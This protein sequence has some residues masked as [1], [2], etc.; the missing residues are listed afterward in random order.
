MSHEQANPKN[1]VGTLD[2]GLID[3]VCASDNPDRPNSFVII[4][5][6]RVIHCNTDTPEEMHHWI[7]LLQKPKGDAKIDGQEFLVRGEES[8]GIW[9]SLGDSRGVRRTLEE[10][11]GVWGSL[12]DSR[13]VRRSL[14]SLEL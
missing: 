7:S 8:G 14:G 5:A 3:S 12:G 11:G 13:G 1:A 2:V 6:N 4:T 9:R 10:S